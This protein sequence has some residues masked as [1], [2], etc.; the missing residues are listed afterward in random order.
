MRVRRLRCMGGPLDGERVEMSESRR[1]YLVT[2]SALIPPLSA[3][4]EV[5]APPH[6]P[7][8]P[9]AR[10]EVARW[11]DP[12]YQMTPGSMFSAMPETVLRYMG[13]EWR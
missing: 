2:H 4:G 10:Y 5:R 7:R 13:T 12:I 8:H 6:L 1:E 3:M 9:V 11:C